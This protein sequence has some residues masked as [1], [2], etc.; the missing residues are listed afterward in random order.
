MR[1][2]KYAIFQQVTVIRSHSLSSSESDRLLEP[3]LNRTG[4]MRSP[5]IPVHNSLIGSDD[6]ENGILGHTGEERPMICTEARVRRAWLPI[7]S[8]RRVT[9][10]WQ[11]ARSD[12]RVHYRRESRGRMV[13]L[14]LDEPALWWPRRA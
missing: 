4:E 10:W 9:C 14:R 7:R 12:F 3:S 11:D 8:G 13:G 6:V 2:D 1:W 5:P